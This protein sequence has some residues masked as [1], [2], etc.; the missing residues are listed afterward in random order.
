MTGWHYPHI[1]QSDRTAFKDALYAY[2]VLY[3]VIAPG[4]TLIHQRTTTTKL[5][6]NSGYHSKRPKWFWRTIPNL[7]GPSPF[8]ASCERPG[9]SAKKKKN[10]DLQRSTDPW[11]WRN[12][13]FYKASN[14]NF[15][16]QIREKS[17]C[18]LLKISKFCSPQTEVCWVAG[19]LSSCPLCLWPHGW[20]WLASIWSGGTVRV[21]I[22]LFKEWRWFFFFL[23]RS[24]LQKQSHFGI[25]I[26][27][28]NIYLIP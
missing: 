25:R 3:E 7:L 15:S 21:I 13:N 23:K 24:F 17:G 8:W 16:L 11:L 1:C 26:E 6:V 12:P 19:C 18:V 28:D 20:W 2:C 9:H 4:I 10:T 5:N 14:K 27:S 22:Q